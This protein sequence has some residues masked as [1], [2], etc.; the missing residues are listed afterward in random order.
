MVCTAYLKSAFFNLKS[1]EWGLKISDFR[2]LMFRKAT[3][4]VKT[5]D[6]TVKIIYSPCQWYS[7]FVEVLIG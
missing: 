5:A 2:F 7:V 1:K 4:R 3:V 6:R